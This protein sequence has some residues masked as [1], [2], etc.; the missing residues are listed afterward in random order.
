MFVLLIE[1]SKKLY[2]GHKVG[3]I[4]RTHGRFVRS[5]VMKYFTFTCF[6][7]MVNVQTIEFALL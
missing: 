2:V 4:C 6:M 5:D 1:H 3:R 7:L